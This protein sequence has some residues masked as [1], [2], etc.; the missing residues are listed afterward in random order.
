[1][2][3]VDYLL[4]EFSAIIRKPNID[5]TQDKLLLEAFERAKQMHEQEVK[6][7][8]IHGTEEQTIENHSIKKIFP[9]QRGDEKGYYN[10]KYNSQNK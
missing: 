4:K 10:R 8:F 9:K 2:T 5:G 3:S 1:M 6:S 7:E